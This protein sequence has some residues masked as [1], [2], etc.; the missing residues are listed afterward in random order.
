MLSPLV[1]QAFADE[2]QKTANA[3][4]SA[5][6]AAGDAATH[7]ITNPRVLFGGG[8]LAGAVGLHQGKKM[9]ND[10]TTGRQ[11]RLA[12]SGGGGYY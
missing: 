3:V 11:I 8:L 10:M 6:H 5:G 12:N 4:T 7:L 2:V 9:W 1:M